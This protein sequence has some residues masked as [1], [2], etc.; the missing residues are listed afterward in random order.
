MSRMFADYIHRQVEEPLPE[1]PPEDWSAS[2]TQVQGHGSLASQ[3]SAMKKQ[4][5]RLLMCRHWS[6]M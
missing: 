6:L 1:L 2:T 4:H 5:V 3:L